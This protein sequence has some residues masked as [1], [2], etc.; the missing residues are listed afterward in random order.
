ME[1]DAFQ[2]TTALLAGDIEYGKERIGATIQMEG[3]R[4]HLE[5]ERLT[6]FQRQAALLH[7]APP[8]QAGEDGAHGATFVAKFTGA[9]ATRLVIG[10]DAIQSFTRA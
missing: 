1:E 8:A 10:V 4:R 7:I 5:I 9:T 2:H 6:I 3:A